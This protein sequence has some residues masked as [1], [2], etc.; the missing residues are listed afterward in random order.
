[1]M[2]NDSLL[3]VCVTLVLSCAQMY[4]IVPIFYAS[5]SRLLLALPPS[6][7]DFWFM[8]IFVDGS[9]SAVAFGCSSPNTPSKR[10]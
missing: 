1:M 9:K 4:F 2:S 8:L 5:F 7:G 3:W 10:E 6:C